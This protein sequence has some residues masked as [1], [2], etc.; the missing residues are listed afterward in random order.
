MKKF[1]TIE[2]GDPLSDEAIIVYYKGK[3]IK[4]L[5]KEELKKV[6]LFAKKLRKTKL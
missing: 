2:C 5:P 3:K 4:A 1:G 6:K